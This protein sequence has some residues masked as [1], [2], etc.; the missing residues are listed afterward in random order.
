MALRRRSYKASLALLGALTHLHTRTTIQP[1]P[2]VQHSIMDYSPIGKLSPE[3]RNMIYELVVG[4]AHVKISCDWHR[5]SDYSPKK[6]VI[7]GLQRNHLALT[8][9][10]KQIRVESISYF[11]STSAFTIT[12]APSVDD[13]RSSRSQVAL[14]HLHASL[15][16]IGPKHARMMKTVDL[17]ITF[18]DTRAIYRDTKILAQFASFLHHAGKYSRTLHM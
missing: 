14:L 15:N 4:N 10:C 17:A 1:P 2:G 8:K 16:S 6:P 13:R 11:Y 9:T 12:V 18:F 5:T 7:S 3:L